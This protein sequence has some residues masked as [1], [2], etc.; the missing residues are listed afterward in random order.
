MSTHPRRYTVPDALRSGHD[1]YMTPAW[2][3]RLWVAHH[4]PAMPHRVVD[5][6]AGDGRIGRAFGAFCLLDL[7]PRAGGVL[8]QN[9][10]ELTRENF[11]G[12]DVSIVANPPFTLAYEFLEKGLELA[13]TDGDV[14]MVLRV[15]CLQQV[16]WAHRPV[17]AYLPKRRVQFEITPEYAEFLTSEA[18]RKGKRPAHSRADCPTG[19]RLGSPGDDHGIFVFRPGW[20]G[21]TETHYID[22]MPFTEAK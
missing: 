14:A 21:P 16:G 2:L 4:R 18:V 1:L 10:L 9:F 22:T 20:T 8:E 13:G 15:G 12:Q 3:L 19:W 17:R 5:P 6:C 7:H 11:G